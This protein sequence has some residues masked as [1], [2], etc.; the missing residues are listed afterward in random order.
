M[1]DI[2]W[3]GGISE[4][5]KIANMAEVYHTPVS[6]HDAN[7]PVSIIAGAHTMMAV[8]NFYRLEIQSPWL[9]TFNS[10]IEPP[11]DIRDGY[12]H[13]SDRPG[14]GVELNLDFIKAHPDPDW[15]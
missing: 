9:E 12:L 1:P 11:L 4:M 5:R 8:P 15:Q 7:A 3:T 13:L 6:P 14:L 2:A 10:C